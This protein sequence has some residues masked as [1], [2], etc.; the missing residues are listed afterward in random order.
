VR[1]LL[2]T[3]VLLWMQAEPDRLG[4]AA[5]ELVEDGANDLLWSAAGSW[6][7]AIKH[8]LG[9]LELPEPALDYVPRVMR[10]QSLTPLPIEHRHALIAGTLPAHHRDPFDRLLV[11]Q[12]QALGIAVMT[13]DPAFNAYDVEVVSAAS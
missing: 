4:P 3:S 5:R 12:G 10:A 8:A 11:A 7:I 1:V 9:R 2:D 13:G 6:E